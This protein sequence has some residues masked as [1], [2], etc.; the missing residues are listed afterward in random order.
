MHRPARGLTPRP[1]RLMGAHGD[2]PRKTLSVCYLAS[3]ATAPRHGAAARGG[4]LR[5]GNG[6]AAHG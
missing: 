2:A 4:E 5:A 6:A 3:R 1:A